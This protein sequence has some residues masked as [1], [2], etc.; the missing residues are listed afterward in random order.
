[1]NNSVIDGAIDQFDKD[2]FKD[3]DI[4]SREWIKWALRI[5]EPST[6]QEYEEMQWLL[7][8][9]FEDFKDR[10][11]KDRQIA[12]RNVRGNGYLIVP[13]G[14]QAQYAAE[15]GIR[16][17]RKGIQEADK[18]LTNVRSEQLT[19][20]ERKRHVDTQ[21]RFDGIKGIMSRQKKDVFAL[22]EYKE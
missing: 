7:L 19:D 14:E 4:I 22:F 10:L 21:C 1:M 15:K 16:H 11:L 8:S 12:L 20:E 9:R 18:L 2:Q 5:K 6:V 13:P 3:G 17:I